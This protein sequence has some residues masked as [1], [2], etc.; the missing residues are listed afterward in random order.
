IFFRDQDVTPAQ[1][2]AFARLFGELE[3]HP[4]LPYREGF[5]EVIVFAKNEQTRG[6]ENNWHS[7]VT[8]RQEP[9]LGSVL[10]AVEVPG[11]GGDTLFCDMYA[12]YE[13]LSDQ[14]RDAID[15]LEA[16][17]DFTRTFRS[18]LDEKTLAEKQKEFPPAT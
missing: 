8:W 4:F 16:T 2:V 14:I 5:P 17:H 12:A 18:M 13:G 10:R 9:S 3:V 7:D 15:G 11:V 1:H 6:Y